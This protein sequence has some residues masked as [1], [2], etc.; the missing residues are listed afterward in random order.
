M[1]SWQVENLVRRLSAAH[2]PWF[3]SMGFPHWETERTFWPHAHIFSK[4]EGTTVGRSRGLQ[5]YLW[6]DATLQGNSARNDPVPLM[7]SSLLQNPVW[8]VQ[9]SNQSLHHPR[10]P[11]TG[12]ITIRHGCLQ[13]QSPLPICTSIGPV[14]YGPLV[15][16]LSTGPHVKNPRAHRKCKYPLMALIQMHAPITKAVCLC[17]C[18]GPRERSQLNGAQ[19]YACGPGPFSHGKALCSTLIMIRLIQSIFPLHLFLP[20]FKTFKW[21]FREIRHLRNNA[22]YYDTMTGL[23]G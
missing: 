18:Q 8:L 19:N 5:R 3:T 11:P 12:S 2:F 16:K 4:R 21:H 17:F 9:T 15:A 14:T 13:E 6:L 22:H 1:L 23:R 20:S 7:G 10:P